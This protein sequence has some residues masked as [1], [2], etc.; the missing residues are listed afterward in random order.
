LGYLPSADGSFLVSCSGIPDHPAHLRREID[1]ERRKRKMRR[2]KKTTRKL[3]EEREIRERKKEM[4]RK[5]G[6]RNKGKK[7]GRERKKEGKERKKEENTRNQINELSIFRNCYS[8]NILSILLLV[9]ENRNYEQHE[10]LK[11]LYYK[12]EYVV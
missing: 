5:K 6:K 12:I 1:E 2:R 3:K 9:N 8:Q 11:K 7:K 4:K 10:G